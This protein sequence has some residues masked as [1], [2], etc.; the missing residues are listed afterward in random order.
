[1]SIPVAQ[2]LEIDRAGGGILR[3]SRGGEDF[4]HAPAG[5]RALSLS[6]SA[7]Q[8]EFSVE[9]VELVL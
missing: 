7:G 4:V 1:M 8:V 9:R 2:R 6:D 3:W 5:T